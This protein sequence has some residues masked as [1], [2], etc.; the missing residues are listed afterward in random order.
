MCHG[1]ETDS[2]STAAQIQFFDPQLAKRHPAMLSAV[3]RRAMEFAGS[4][5][6]VVPTDRK[7]C[8]WLEWSMQVT[9]ESGSELFIGA[10]QR[11]PDAT[12]EFH[13]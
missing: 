9:Y 1:T 6:R 3:T 10:I 7:P 4:S 13:S 5:I 12:V 2:P 11:H 8:G